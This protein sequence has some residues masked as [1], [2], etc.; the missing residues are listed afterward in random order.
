M[1]RGTPY[2]LTVVSW[3]L[4]Y[5]TPGGG[6]NTVANRQAV[7]EYL[8]DVGPDVVLAQECRPEDAVTKAGGRFDDYVVVGAI[9]PRRT[10]CSVVVARRDLAPTPAER[11]GLLLEDLGG[12]VALA[13]I[14]LPDRKPWLLGS[15]HA[16]AKMI[17][18]EW[19]TDAERLRIGRP[20]TGEAWHNDAAVT[21]I[22]PL[23]ESREA[24]VV[25]GDFNT[26]R[27]YDDHSTFGQ[28]PSCRAWFERR[29]DR[30]WFDA[31]RRFH[32]DDQR[33]YLKPGTGSYEL[34]H[35]FVDDGLLD[36]LTG[37]RVLDA[38]G[39]SDHAPLLIELDLGSA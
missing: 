26:C 15:V 32:P 28:V 34:D 22:E 25:G 36:H 16:P 7:W 23:A 3:K 29:Q 30:G 35:V 11:P 10:A 33:T 20:E 2:R 24:F 8:A 12:Y 18:P 37:C 4:G 31:M 1:T 6:F 9:P 19:V 13:V 38:G 14:R 27:A 21:A 5:W 39:L 17:P